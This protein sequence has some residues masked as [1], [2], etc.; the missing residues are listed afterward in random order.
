MIFMVYYSHEW[1]AQRNCR[2]TPVSLSVILSKRRQQLI[3]VAEPWLWDVGLGVLRGALVI[4]H[5]KGHSGPVW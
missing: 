4:H 2:Q 1:L 3:S 5:I